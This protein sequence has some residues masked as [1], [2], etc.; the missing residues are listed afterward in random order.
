MDHYI[1][2]AIASTMF[3]AIASLSAGLL[4]HGGLK[5]INRSRVVFSLALLCAGFLMSIEIR[6]VFHRRQLSLE[7]HR[8]EVYECDQMKALKDNPNVNGECVDLRKKLQFTRWQ[9]I[10][11][12]IIKAIYQEFFG[13]FATVGYIQILSLILM[14]AALRWYLIYKAKSEKNAQLAEIEKGRQESQERMFQG[15]MDQKSIAER[16]ITYSPTT[17][18]PPSSPSKSKLNKNVQEV[19]EEETVPVE[20]V[21]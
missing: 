13:R 12:E 20:E 18:T 2:L 9:W 5:G 10:Q 14:L 15:L 11:A 3:V 21:D 1:D 8:E 19:E 16:Y 4:L 7:K 6:D 17:A